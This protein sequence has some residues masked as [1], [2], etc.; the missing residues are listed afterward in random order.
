M[1]VKTAR[2]LQGATQVCTPPRETA[3]KYE[4]WQIKTPRPDITVGFRHD[5]FCKALE[6]QG[7]ESTDVV[8]FL[9]SYQNNDWLPSEGTK[10]SMAMRMPFLIVEGK[11]HTTGGHILEGQNQ[12][13]VGVASLG[14]LLKKLD[15]LVPKDHHSQRRGGKSRGSK[16]V[17]NR[18][19]SVFLIC[20]QGYVLELWAYE[21]EVHDGGLNH[22]IGLVTSANALVYNQL[23]E[24]LLFLAKL[25]SWASDEHLVNLAKKVVQAK[26]AACVQA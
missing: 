18:R 16:L 2:P 5:V 1:S 22:K 21:M 10:V 13:M 19:A 23:L 7:M 20:T 9:N 26:A 11:S 8:D 6:K 12:G 24:L 4:D 17:Q 15:D 25:F 3:V 14:L